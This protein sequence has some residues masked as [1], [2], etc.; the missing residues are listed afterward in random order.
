MFCRLVFFSA[1]GPCTQ[2]F[3][4][5]RPAKKQK[6]QNLGKGHPIFERLCELF[7]TEQI[8]SDEE[9]HEVRDRYPE[10]QDN[11]Y[12]TSRFRGAFNRAK[13]EVQKKMAKILTDGK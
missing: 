8:Q 6:L 7:T 9:P 10:L 5:P 1:G 3:A 4:M 11:R 12:S 2:I 13:K